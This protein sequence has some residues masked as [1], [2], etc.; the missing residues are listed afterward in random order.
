MTRLA[1]VV[2]LSVPAAPCVSSSGSGEA[3]PA[4]P[5]PYDPVGQYTLM[6]KSTPTNA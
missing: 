3:D 4:P 6:Y 1:G 5:H 2:G